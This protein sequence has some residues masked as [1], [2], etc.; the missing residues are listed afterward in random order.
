MVEPV[1]D[2]CILPT[3]VRIYIMYIAGIP[4]LHI[5]LYRLHCLFEM[6]V[7]LPWFPQLQINTMSERH[8]EALHEVNAQAAGEIECSEMSIYSLEKS[9]PTCLHLHFPCMRPPKSQ[10]HTYIVL[11]PFKALGIAGGI[12]QWSI[13]GIPGNFF[14]FLGLNNSQ[15]PAIWL[16]VPLEA[17]TKCN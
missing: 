12:C 6:L 14:V 3:Y 7:H 11:K 4:S 16:R 2:W 17:D 13:M 5:R 15:K 1:Q 8:R 9:R 10:L